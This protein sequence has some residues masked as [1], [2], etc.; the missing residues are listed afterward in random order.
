VA[1]HRLLP[2]HSRVESYMRI[3]ALQIVVSLAT[4]LVVLAIIGDPASDAQNDTTCGLRGISAPQI[5]RAQKV[6]DDPEATTA[7]KNRNRQSIQSIKAFLSI[8]HT[9]PDDY[10]CP[11]PKPKP[12]R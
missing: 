8:Y 7:E 4:V 1:P 10:K 3:A 11:E 12:T 2:H 5:A 6:L 9:I